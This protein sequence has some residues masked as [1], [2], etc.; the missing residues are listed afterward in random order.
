MGGFQNFKT[1]LQVKLFRLLFC[2]ISLQ[3]YCS[4]ELHSVC[5]YQVKIYF[6]VC[7]EVQKLAAIFFMSILMILLTWTF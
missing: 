3:F 2:L 6:K 5:F 7:F 1:S 4:I